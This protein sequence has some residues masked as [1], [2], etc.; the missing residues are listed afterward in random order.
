VT[1]PLKRI[2]LLGGTFDPVHNAHV[3]LARAAL[4]TL[5]LDQVRW[6][7]TGAPWQKTRRITP[8]DHRVA[9]L[10]LAISGEPRFVLERCEIERTG[11][12]YTLD[13]VRELLRREPD[14]EWILILGQDQFSNLHS[15]RG[16]QELVSLV[17]LA[18]AARA[19]AVVATDAQWPRLA[20]RA[21]PLAPMNVSASAIRERVSRGEPID[22]LVPPAVAHYIGQHGLYLPERA[23]P[24]S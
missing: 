6:V 18:V 9:M 10:E 24:G 5:S 20:Y 2:G 17:T 14:A 11:P 13:T 1:Q 15:W 4:D 8:A 22:D 23:S 3:A 21:L 7:P 16:W 12:S 19:D